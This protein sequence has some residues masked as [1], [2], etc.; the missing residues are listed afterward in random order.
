MDNTKPRDC[1]CNGYHTDYAGPELSTSTLEVLK[2]TEECP[3]ERRALA[4]IIAGRS[5]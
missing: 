2:Q 4:R 3:A 1:T 5:S